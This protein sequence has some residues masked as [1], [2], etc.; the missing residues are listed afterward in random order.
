MSGGLRWILLAQRIPFSREGSVLIHLSAPHIGTDLP[1]R[2]PHRPSLHN[3]APPD[4]RS[5]FPH[6]PYPRPSPSPPARSLAHLF[7][8]VLLFGRLW[9]SFPPGALRG[10]QVC[11]NP[12]PP[13][14]PN[15]EGGIR[16][17]ASYTHPRCMEKSQSGHLPAAG[18]RGECQAGRC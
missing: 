16:I 15:W 4:P 18:E 10:R 17:L 14:C 1:Y 5:T 9:V 12:S 13:R 3:A 8:A 11:R 7:P 2:H 6:R